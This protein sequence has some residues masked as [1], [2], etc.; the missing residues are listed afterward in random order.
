MSK[1]VSIIIV[2]LTI[3][4]CN[5][6]LSTKEK[7]AYTKKG[8]EIVQASFKELSSNL[9]QQMKQGGPAQAVPFCNTQ[10]M[11]ITNNMAKK[12]DVTIKR[13]SDKVRNQDNKATERELQIIENYKNLQS[14]NK[15]LVPIVEIDN[16]S[17]KHF[18][19]PII[20]NEKCLVCHGKLEEKLSIKTDSIIKS[21]YP[22]D[23]AIGYK[24]GDLRGIW[25]V[26]FK[27]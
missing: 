9:M 26:E 21:L 13:T 22:N 10:A 15:K 4:A 5:N 12:F 7:E 14:E 11:P 2:L 19:A 27:K 17:K 24:V 8:K 25:S 18:Y 6:S 3:T 16:N 1:Y 23:V 20:I